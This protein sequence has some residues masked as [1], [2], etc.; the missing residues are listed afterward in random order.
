MKIKDKQKGVMFVGA[1]MNK[2][3]F[4]NDELEVRATLAN[5]AMISL[6]NARLF[7]VSLESRFRSSGQHWRS[8]RRQ[9][10]RRDQSDRRSETGRIGWRLRCCRTQIDDRKKRPGD[11]AFDPSLI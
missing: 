8:D 9:A 3:Q 1:K 4:Q 11:D 6:E 7:R 2:Q 5:Q 10:G